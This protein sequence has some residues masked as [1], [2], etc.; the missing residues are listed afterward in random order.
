[1]NGVN[2]QHRKRVSKAGMGLGIWT[3]KPSSDLLPVPIYDDSDHLSSIYLPGIH[4]YT[5]LLVYL[6]VFCR[7]PGNKPHLCIYHTWMSWVEKKM[8]VACRRVLGN[9]SVASHESHWFLNQTWV[10]WCLMNLGQMMWGWN[11]IWVWR[12]DI[13]IRMI[14]MNMNHNIN[15]LNPL[16]WISF[17]FIC[18]ICL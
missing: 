18:M 5:C 12:V 6:S 11:Y 8:R 13:N 1:M 16:C 14:I 15:I 10:S 9:W 17:Y 4:L 2:G 7:Y 3:P